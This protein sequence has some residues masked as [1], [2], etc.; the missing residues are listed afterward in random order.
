MV[1][2]AAPFIPLPTVLCEKMNYPGPQKHLVKNFLT[3]PGVADVLCGASVATSVHLLAKACLSTSYSLLKVGLSV[4]SAG[5]S[6]SC[7]TI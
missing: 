2:S 6:S 5:H 1:F 7:A 4:T 3:R